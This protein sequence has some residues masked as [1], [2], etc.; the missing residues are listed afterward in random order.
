[1]SIRT[2]EVAVKQILARNYD[3]DKQTEIYPFISAASVIVDRVITCAAAKSI[4]LTTT[5]TELIERWLAAHFY[6]AGPDLL[7][8][9]KSTAGASASF[10]GQT[11]MHLD[12]T[13]YGQMAKTLDYSGCLT[14]ID[15]RQEQTAGGRASGFWL[16]KAPSAQTD[17]RDRD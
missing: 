6:C 11:G 7:Y 2:T 4:T 10:Q 14:E 15:K 17:Y 3:E 13:S 8:S 9:S 16:G 12:S 1:M 5:E